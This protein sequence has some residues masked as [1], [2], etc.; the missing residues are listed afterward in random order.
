M[1]FSDTALS[2]STTDQNVWGLRT[3]KGGTQEERYFHNLNNGSAPWTAES[4]GSHFN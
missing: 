2:N 1:K 4:G 3:I